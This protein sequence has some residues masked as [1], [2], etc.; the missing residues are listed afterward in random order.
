MEAEYQALRAEVLQLFHEQSGLTYVTALGSA[1]MLF[2]VFQG[3][4]PVGLGAVLWELVLV[5]ISWKLLGNYNRLYRLTT[6]IK[7]VH[8]QEF[9]TDRQPE[10]GHP[11]W[12]CRSR[13]IGEYPGAKWKWGTGPKIDCRFL[14]LI[15]LG[16]PLLTLLGTD[17]SSPGPVPGAG[18]LTATVASYGYLYY[19]TRRLNTLRE[20]SDWFERELFERFGD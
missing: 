19:S 11:A 1:A 6:Y 17:W 3:G 14:R 12:L 5:G 16:G 7:V 8:E 10:K 9:D 18:W 15:G 13:A 2:A 20:D 4:L